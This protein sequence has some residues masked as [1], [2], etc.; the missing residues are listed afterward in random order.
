MRW[1]REH[2]LPVAIA[3]LLLFAPAARA[4]LRAGVGIG[5]VTPPVGTPS[6]GYGDRMGAGMEGVHDP[7]LA[8]ALAIDNGS[9]R[10][11]LVGVDHLGFDHAMVQEVRAAVTADPVGGDGALEIHVGASHTH[12]G[13]G[14]YL[15]IPG[16]GAVL[17][18]AFDPA[19]R[20][21]YVDGAAAAARAALA[22]LRPARVGIGYGSAPGLSSYRG[23]WPPDVE[24]V[25]AVTVLKVTTPE[26]EPLAVWLDYPAHA[27]VLPGR[28][29]M[30]FS[31]DFVGFARQA[32][33]ERLGEGVVAVYFNGAQGDVSPRPPAG[34]DMWAR[35]EAMGRALAERVAEIWDAT[36]TRDRLEIETRRHAY[37]VEV[38]PTSSGT[39][40]PF[41]RRSSE[42][43]LIVLDRRHALL[44]IPGE[45]STIYDANLRRF[46]RWLGY[47]QLTVLGLTD[48]AHGYIITPESFRHRTYES[49]VSF[50][51]ELY[52]EWVESAASALLHALEPEGS[53]QEDRRL[54]SELL[55]VEPATPPR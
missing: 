43:N 3:A 6:A 12:A 9:V 26:G 40:L 11:V 38:R 5:D 45:L 16:L 28:E 17:A 25:D 14:A 23:D 13:G 8:T 33:Q 50:G 4:E 2:S 51:G 37:D 30:R 54:D 18:G 27:T 7:L 15:D 29:N 1:I 44:T 32:L 53:H 47:E 39:R 22:A 55:R 46:A 52:G 35:A 21:L 34:D 31:A 24:T 49:T 19:A 48:D 20:Q 41:E 10:L 42:L 36:D